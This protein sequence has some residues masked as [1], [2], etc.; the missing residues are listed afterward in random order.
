MSVPIEGWD[1]SFN[2]GRTEDQPL[3]WSYQDLARPLVA[4]ARR[5]LD[6][7]TG[8]GEIL[9]SL[10][11]PTGSVAVEP[12]APNVP[13]AAARLGPLGVRVIERPSE[14]LP[15]AD[16]E[17][18]LV[19]NR[20]GHLDSAEIH[21]AM[22]PGG[23]LLTQ[24]VAAQ[25]DLEFND[26][27]GIPPAF[28]PTAPI[29]LSRLEEELQRAGLVIIEAREAS[30]RTR[31]LDVGAVIY[32]LRIVSWQAPGFDPIRH[33]SELRRIHDHIVRTGGFDVH[34]RRF[35]VQARK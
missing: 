33:R 21:R 20:H 18:D 28:D 32:Q 16:G 6:I 5:V 25:N 8:G 35:L 23:L 27:L 29:S 34:S 3:P 1:F 15:V 12:H 30:I 4:R 14:R 10:R 19:L 31:Y 17:F 13:V 24:Q 7:D 11:P 22:T 2:R 26:A 9:G